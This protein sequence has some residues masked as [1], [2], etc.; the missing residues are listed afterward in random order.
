[1]VVRHVEA[2]EKIE[3]TMAQEREKGLSV[4]NVAP[5]ASVA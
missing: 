5:F 4:A 1:M 2:F 3:T